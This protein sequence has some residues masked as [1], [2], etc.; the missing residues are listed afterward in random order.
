[1]LLLENLV[2]EVFLVEVVVRIFYERKIKKSGRI[3]FLLIFEYVFNM[4]FIGLRL[5]FNWIKI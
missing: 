5:E 1:M 4:N 2:S 3:C